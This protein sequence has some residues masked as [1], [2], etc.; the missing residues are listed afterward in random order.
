[1]TTQLGSNPYTTGLALRSRREP[2]V[3]HTETRGA[4]TGSIIEHEGSYS[5]EIVH[6]GGSKALHPFPYARESDARERLTQGWR[7]MAY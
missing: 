3:L 5:T 1:M 6:A 4:W 2:V 7:D